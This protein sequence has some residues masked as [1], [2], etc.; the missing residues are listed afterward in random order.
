MA[1][2]G[3]VSDEASTDQLNLDEIRWFNMREPGPSMRQ[4]VSRHGLTLGGIIVSLVLL[5]SFTSL[6]MAMPNSVSR[7]WMLFGCAAGGIWTQVLIVAK[8]YWDRRRTAKSESRLVQG[9][10]DM[11]SLL[12]LVRTEQVD[13]RT[14]VILL[15]AEMHALLGLLPQGV[16]NYGDRR[17]VEVS[18]EAL[19]RQRATGTDG[20]DARG[21]AP[22]I[23]IRS[24]GRGRQ[25]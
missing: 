23:D 24:T 15:R 10:A 5:A 3:I 9:Q 21:V 2:Y 6:D 13:L 8:W 25:S 22:V 14:Q 20:R 17:S 16:I 18:V 4:W 19:Q 12:T 11:R 1:L 7:S